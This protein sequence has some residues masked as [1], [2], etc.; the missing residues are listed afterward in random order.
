MNLL[1]SG[2]YNVNLGKKN[3]VCVAN[4]QKTHNMLVSLILE[5]E[6]TGSGECVSAVEIR[7]RLPGQPE[8]KY[9]FE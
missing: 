7:S 8:I 4:S 1:S 3:Y 2:P 9:G 6:A 5:V